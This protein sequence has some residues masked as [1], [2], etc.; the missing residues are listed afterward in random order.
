MEKTLAFTHRYEPS[1]RAGAPTLLLLHGTGGNE[2]DLL[3]LGRMI[4]PGAALLSPR[5]KVLENGA[6]RFFRRLAEGVFDLQDLAARTDELADFVDSAAVRYGFDPARVVGVGYSN[7]ANIASSLLFRRPGALAAAVLFRPMVPFEPATAVDL[8]G[9]G[10][11]MSSGRLDPI[12]PLEHPER[13][14]Q[15][16]SDAGAD[17][18]L[19][20]HPGGHELS[21]EDLVAAREWVEGASMSRPPGRKVRRAGSSGS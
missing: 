16:L 4:A 10:V 8:R 19:H 15:L 18:T 7:G 21:D 12:V 13:L 3:P 17:V 6:P 20:W 14:R 1:A 2:D 9:V 5:G 11:F